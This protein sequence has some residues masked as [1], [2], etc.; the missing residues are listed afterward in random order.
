MYQNRRRAVK[1]DIDKVTDS[2]DVKQVKQLLGLMISQDASNRPSIQ[3]VVSTLN[4]LL[5]T[6]R[7]KHL[8]ANPPDF[9]KSK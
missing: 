4:Y 6:L 5:T 7:A 9:L 1:V 3:E 2:E 8:Q